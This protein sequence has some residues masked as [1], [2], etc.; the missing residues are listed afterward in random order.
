MAVLGEDGGHAHVARHSQQLNRV[1]AGQVAFPAGE[2]PAS[3]RLGHEGHGVVVDV[4]TFIGVQRDRA[5]D[6]RLTQADDVDFDLVLILDKGG[7]DDRVVGDGQLRFGVGRGNGPAPAAERPA[8]IGRGPQ[9]HH[10]AIDVGALQ[11]RGRNGAAGADAIVDNVERQVVLFLDE[12]GRNGLRLQHRHRDGGRRAVDRAAPADEGPTRL[13]HGRQLDDVAIDVGRLVRALHHG[14]LFA[15]DAVVVDDDVEQV[16][17]LGEGGDDVLGRVDDN[18][19]QRRLTGEIATVAGERPTGNRAGAEH[20]FIAAEVSGLVRLLGD[21]TGADDGD[22]DAHRVA[23]FGHDRDVVVEE[24]VNDRRVAGGRAGRAGG[25]GKHADLDGGHVHR[26]GRLALPLAVLI[27]EALEAVADA[28]DAQ[29]CRQCRAF[30][31]RR[32]GALHNDAV[33]DEAAEHDEA[34]GGAFKGDTDVGVGVLF[35]QDALHLS[36]GGQ[37]RLEFDIDREVTVT[38]HLHD[39][40]RAAIGPVVGTAAG[41]AERQR[42]ARH[43]QGGVALRIDLGPDWVEQAGVEVVGQQAAKLIGREG[44]VVGRAGVAL[45]VGAQNAEVVACAG[46]EAADFNRV[47]GLQHIGLA[48]EAE[49]IVRRLAI[50]YAAGGRLAAVPGDVGSVGQGGDDDVAEGGRRGVGRRGREL[51]GDRGHAVAQQVTALD[52]DVVLGRKAEVAGRVVDQAVVAHNALNGRLVGA[53]DIVDSEFD[54]RPVDAELVIAEAGDDGRLD[55]D[56]G[57]VGRG[58]LAADNRRSH[59][60]RAGGGAAQDKHRAG[61][62]DKVAGA[63]TGV[64]EGDAIQAGNEEVL[65]EG[66]NSQR[67]VG[68]TDGRGAAAVEGKVRVAPEG[69]DQIGVRKVGGDAGRHGEV[70]VHGVRPLAVHVQAEVV[71]VMDDVGVDGHIAHQLEVGRDAARALAHV[72]RRVNHANLE[73]DDRLIGDVAHVPRCCCHSRAIFGLD[74]SDMVDRAAG[75]LLFLAAGPPVVAAQ[76][77]PIAEDTVVVFVVAFVPGVELDIERVGRDFGGQLQGVIVD[78]QR[79]ARV[80]V[81]GAAVILDGDQPARWRLYIA[82]G[83]G[84]QGVVVGMVDADT[85][86]VNVGRTGGPEG[87]GV[88][89][90]IQFRLVDFQYPGRAAPVEADG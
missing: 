20:D 24:V 2:R 66:A 71:E 13:R 33:F 21:C 9:R 5:A 60:G 84:Q 74:S 77:V 53:V 55:F 10:I 32:R 6:A 22:V 75:G 57:S 34:A 35:D 19:R 67:P 11:R 65:V 42:L 68:R 72:A 45:L 37:G 88:L 90:D 61:L 41:E 25:A 28:L 78:G 51:V 1:G 62:L 76:V 82:A 39:A 70:V 44:V 38:S 14:V 49:F 80:G 86:V 85:D 47:A 8:L 81:D 17:V 40:R 29:H 46:L 89:P 4:A 50:L 83:T 69:T 52:L 26:V 58:Q 54:R 36:D 16:L 59:V 31:K 64:G 79:A 23:V 48:H 30:D 56:V 73:A 15:A 43:G 12:V 18:G 63:G 7:V 3:I 27:V 87:Y